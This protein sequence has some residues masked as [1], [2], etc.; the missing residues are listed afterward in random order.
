M[1]VSVL[2]GRDGTGLTEEDFGAWIAYAD[3]ALGKRMAGADEAGLE[4]EIESRGER[5]QLQTDH[6][7]GD[8]P[9]MVETVQAALRDAWESYCGEPCV[10]PSDSISQ[11]EAIDTHLSRCGAQDDSSA[12]VCRLDDA[13]TV[14]ITDGQ[15]EWVGD[16]AEALARL[17]ALPDGCGW[18]AVWE[19]L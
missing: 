18:D 12:I 5:D 19:A 7:S 11:V 17:A 16:P 8:D 2:L 10:I 6:V 4:I 13:G 1:R 15:G 9:E 3:A 14:T